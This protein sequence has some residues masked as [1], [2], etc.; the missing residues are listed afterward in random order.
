MLRVEDRNVSPERDEQDAIECLPEPDYDRFSCEY[1]LN[2]SPSLR[3]SRYPGLEYWLMTN[4]TRIM[5]A[6]SE[7]LGRGFEFHICT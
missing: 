5:T 6:I 3:V 4:L 7:A 2:F 1:Y